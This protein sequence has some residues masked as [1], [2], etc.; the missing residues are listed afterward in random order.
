MT[1]DSRGPRTATAL[2]PRL[3]EHEDEDD[4]DDAR[5]APERRVVAEPRREEPEEPAPEPEPE[6]DRD[7]PDRGRDREGRPARP[8]EHVELGEGHQ[9]ARPEAVQGGRRD[10]VPGL[11][12][13][14]E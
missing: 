6:V 11:E 12:P 2:R 4:C 13:R 9:P 10:H 8:R 7:V 5:E 14:R 1:I 3:D